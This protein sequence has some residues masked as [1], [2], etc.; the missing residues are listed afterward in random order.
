MQLT[1][2]ALTLLLGLVLAAYVCALLWNLVT[3]CL[4]VLP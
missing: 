2:L 3:W 1:P 4:E